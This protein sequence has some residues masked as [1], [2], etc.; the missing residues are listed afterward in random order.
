[1]LIEELVNKTNAEYQRFQD[2]VQQH[3]GPLTVEQLTNNVTTLRDFLMMIIDSLDASTTA[4]SD[5]LT[6]LRMNLSDMNVNDTINMQMA[7]YQHVKTTLDHVDAILMRTNDFN[8]T[9]TLLNGKVVNS[10]SLTD[11]A[12]QLNDSSNE[13]LESSATRLDEVKTNKSLVSDAEALANV[14]QMTVNEALTIA[15]HAANATAAT[16][17]LELEFRE[18]YENN[19]KK[20]MSLIIDR[21]A[22][23]ENLG[24]YL[25]EAQNATK[26]AMAANSTASNAWTLANQKLANAV[27]DNDTASEI[28]SNASVAFNAACEVY[29]DT[30]DAKERAISANG[31]ANLV[32]HSIAAAETMLKDQDDVLLSITNTTNK[33]LAL[34]LPPLDEI[35]DL[36]RQINETIIPESIVNETIDDANEAYRRAMEVDEVSRKA[37]NVSKQAAE[38]V[39]G[40]ETNIAA[41]EENQTAAEGKIKETEAVIAEVHDIKADV[42]ATTDQIHIIAGESMDI[43]GQ[44]LSTVKMVEECRNNVITELVDAN[45]MASTACSI[46]GPEVLMN[47]TRVHNKAFELNASVAVE[48]AEEDL[49]LAGS[50]LSESQSLQQSVSNSDLIQALMELLNDYTSQKQELMGKTTRLEELDQELDELEGQLEHLCGSS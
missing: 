48:K 43:A 30:T 10:Q 12:I 25:E 46:T 37:L 2:I 11:L 49:N 35:T 5:K 9:V 42:N 4:I 36:S 27:T 16:R 19:T 18:L 33:T 7:L 44:A 41:A 28:K 39:D 15:E 24:M 38:F 21:D 45:K 31:T 17:V 40:I 34:S 22:I 13:A 20:L 32:L 6:A 47:A 29:N 1:M 3:Y 26:A 14:A 8:G 50:L 23:S